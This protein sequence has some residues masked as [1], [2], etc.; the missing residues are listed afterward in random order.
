MTRLT[1]DYIR[2]NVEP[3]EDQI[4]GYDPEY[5]LIDPTIL[6]DNIADEISVAHGNKP[7]FNHDNHS[8]WEECDYD[9]WYDFRVI[10]DNETDKVEKFLIE[11]YCSNYIG[12]IELDEKCNRALMENIWNYYGGKDSYKELVKE[13]N[14]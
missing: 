12:E 2:M 5:I 8:D 13:Y 7:F 6:L 4:D 3:T 10:V 1:A 9:G 11:D 14:S